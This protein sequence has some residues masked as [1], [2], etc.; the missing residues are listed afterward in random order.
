MRLKNIYSILFTIAVIPL[1]YSQNYTLQDVK[2]KAKE[3]NYAIKNSSLEIEEAKAIKKEA[4]T[5]YLP[6][7]NVVAVGAKAIDPLLKLKMPGGNLPVY[8]GNPANLASATQFA[9]FPGVNMGLLNQFGLGTFNI[10]QNL[11]AGNKVNTGNKLASLNLDVKKQQQNLLEKELMLKAEREF[12]LV[13]TLKE[14]LKTIDGYETF[15]KKLHTEVNDAV[16]NGLAIRNDLLKVEIKQSELKIKRI[17]LNNGIKL[18]TK[19]LCQTTGLEYTETL[20]FTGDLDELEKPSSLYTD[21][22]KAIVQ[23]GEY[24]LLE[25]SVKATQLQTKME[26]GDLLP[27]I[28][29]GLTGYYGN[30]FEKNSKGVFNGIGYLG[31]TIPISNLWEKKHKIKQKKLKEEIAQNTMKDNVGLLNL[32]MDK[33]W[34]DLNEMNDKVWLMQE[35]LTQTTENLRVQKDSYK[36]GLTSLSDL[37]EAQA[38]V[39]ETEVNLIEAKSQY[40]Q[41][42]SKYLTVTAR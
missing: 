8:D 14:K 37:L 15:L 6:K 9:F 38:L 16:K 29:M 28:G 32:Q 18:V 19:Q 10:T 26:K 7:V 33:A 2:Q 11:F 34:N 3:S 40:K 24:Q 35:T 22:G 25:K 30:S 17:Q 42:I 23:R 20:N 36:N 5:N 4:F 1:S 39:N 31:I 21:K 12:W 41:A 27:T 13:I